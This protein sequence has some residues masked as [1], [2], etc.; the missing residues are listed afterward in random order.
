M[1]QDYG[2][3]KMTKYFAILKD[4]KEDGITDLLKEIIYY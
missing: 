2:T 3:R 1:L 4:V